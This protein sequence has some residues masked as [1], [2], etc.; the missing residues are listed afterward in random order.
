MAREYKHGV[1]SAIRTHGKTFKHTLDRSL[2]RNFEMEKNTQSLWASSV[3]NI[4]VYCRK[5]HE[6][7]EYWIILWEITINAENIE[8]YYRKLPL[9]LRILNYTGNDQECWEYWIILQEITINAENI[10]LHYRKWPR[11]LRILYYRKWPRMRR[12]LNYTTGNDH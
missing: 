7:G 12:I 3:W 5:D 10:E 8:L 9:M 6:C 11:M 4:E 1:A 2:K